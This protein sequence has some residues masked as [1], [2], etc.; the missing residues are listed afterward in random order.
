MSSTT[1]WPCLIVLGGLG[2]AACA[3]GLAGQPDLLAEVKR[4]YDRY[5][6]EEGGLCGSPQF[7][8]VTR[9]SI[10]E[11]SADRLIVQVSY[12]Y[13]QPNVLPTYGQPYPT[14]T[15]GPEGKAAITQP[16]VTGPT[17][18]RGSSSR[19]FTVAKR[20]DG[21]EV[22]AMTG[23]QRQGIKINKIDDSK[24]W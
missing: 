19:R 15:V 7:G 14:P 16:G 6:M 10:E 11:Q 22:L 3:G 5:A 9:S 20:A 1:R 24:V 21:F 2:L 8:L 23:P 17:Q 4:Y 12:F 18:C 13:S